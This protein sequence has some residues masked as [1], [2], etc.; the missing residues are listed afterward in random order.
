MESICINETQTIYNSIAMKNA[1]L[2]Y[3]LK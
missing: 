2:W 3:L 1:C